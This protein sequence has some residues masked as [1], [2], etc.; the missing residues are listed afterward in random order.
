MALNNK[1]VLAVI[2]ARYESSRFPGK[3]L[4]RIDNLTILEIVI[5][6][7]QKSKNITKIIVACSNNEKDKEI[8]KICHKL[9]IQHFVGDEDNVLKRFYYAAKKSKIE[10]IVRITSDC[11]LIDYTIVDRVIEYFLSKK[12][13]YAS[14]D[15]KTFPDGMDVEVFSFNA[16]ES[17]YK[18]AISKVDKEHVTQFIINN[19]KFKKIYLKNNKNYSLLRLTLDEPIDLILIKK[20]FSYFDKNIFFLLKDII[21]L[22][23]K[24]KKL[25]S[26][27]NKISRNEGLTLNIGQKMWKR[28]QKV[29][30]GGSMLF[31]KNPDLFL[32]Q[33][34]P[35]Y[36]SKSN[37]CNVWDLT[38]KKYLDISLM[39]VGTNILGYRRREIDNA[40]KNVINSGNMTTLNS[41][42]EILLAEKLIEMHPWSQMAKFTRSGGEASAVAIRIARAASAKDNV[43]VCGYH[44]WHDWYLSAN[45]HNPNNL[46]SHLMKNLPILGVPKDLKNSVYSFEYNNFEKFEGLISKHN[47]GTVIM[48]VSRNNYP[49]NNFLKKIRNV[50]KKKNIVLIFDECTS[51]FRQTYGG[52]HLHYKVEPD[53]VLFGKALG[54]GYAINAILG[55]EEVMQYANSTFISSTFWTERIGYAAALETLNVMNKIKSWK[56]ITQI[57]RKI[58]RNWKILSDKYNLNLIIEGLD[59]LPRFDFPGIQNLY[60]KTYITQEF[61]KKNILA[62]NTIYLCVEHDNKI[63]KNYFEVLEEIFLKISKFV[64]SNDNSEILLDGPISIAGIR[65]KI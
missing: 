62:S 50:T 24:N 63:I 26:I 29:I 44:G 64:K 15:S 58:K 28:A 30:P 43:A 40:V 7:L 13:D 35:A 49:K 5:R 65:S 22:Y 32:P 34:W 31:S 41:K 27:N 38:G 55:K 59:A 61:L 14:T 12:V 45:L 1:K 33:F 60:L 11:P 4:K 47:I 19:K 37:K 25:F 46:N 36:F 52:L 51:G 17:A 48:E 54:N 21:L 53:I 20:I 6:R 23:K 8:I 3:I 16:L 57:G 10:N 2:Q 18:K 42:E 9:N 56:I 39:G